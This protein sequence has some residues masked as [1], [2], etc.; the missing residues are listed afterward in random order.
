M[1]FKI[2]QSMTLQLLISTYNDGIN[3]I[4]KMLLPHEE[5]IFYLVTWQQSQD[6]SPCVLPAEL[7]RADVEI[8]PLKGLGLSHNRNNCLKHATADIC[9]IADDDCCYTVQGLKKVI[10]T[11]GAN[12]DL[13]LAT[14]QMKNE[15]EPKCYPHF[16]FDL[17]KARSVKNYAVFSV[18]IAFRRRSIV[19][20][21]AFDENFGLCSGVFHAG[22]DSIFI[23]DAIDAGLN[24]R[25]F[26]VEVLENKGATTAT[27]R[28][29]D[30]K[31]IMA[32]GAYLYRCY[33]ST[34]YLRSV[35]ISWRM[36]RRHGVSFFYAL[37]NFLKGIKKM[38]ELS[39]K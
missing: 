34:M 20:K 2:S 24:C 13:D 1:S 9:M 27:T 37:K 17:K 15:D 32:E 12:P 23:Q 3:R 29:H 11:F 6:Y 26:P 30:E 4:P 14:F 22:E 36:H 35:V 16:S 25:Y 10:E 8:F 18:E 28:L 33:R 7:S 19:N 38:R 5:G 39:G 31:V 21:I